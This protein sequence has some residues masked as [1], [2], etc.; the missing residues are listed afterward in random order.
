MTSLMD[1]SD[2]GITGRLYIHNV[3]NRW[4]MTS[5]SGGSDIAVTIFYSLD[6][7]SLMKASGNNVTD[8]WL[9]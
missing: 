5:L 3:T 7:E 9:R 6:D 4:Y 2:D 1:D 8:G